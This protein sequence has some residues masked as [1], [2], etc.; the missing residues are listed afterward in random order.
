MNMND[1]NMTVN[2]FVFYFLLESQI[3]KVCTVRVNTDFRRHSTFGSRD[4]IS[5][6]I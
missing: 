1:M 6:G 3:L 2:I 5:I 4:R